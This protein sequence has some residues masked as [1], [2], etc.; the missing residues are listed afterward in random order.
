MRRRHGAAF[1]LPL[2]ALLVT[3][4]A[5]RGAPTGAELFL[6]AA[7]CAASGVAW[8]VLH[9]RDLVDRLTHFAAAFTV[10]CAVYALLWDVEVSSSL[11]L[12]VGLGA[13]LTGLVYAEQWLRGRDARHQRLLTRSRARSSTSS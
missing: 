9:R 2:G 1:L 6:V 7:L 12:G 3:P 13:V 5:G 8:Q 10:L 11:N 4:D